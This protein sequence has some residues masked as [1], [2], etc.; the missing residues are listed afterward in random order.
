MAEYI[1]SKE[2]QNETSIKIETNDRDFFIGIEEALHQ[3]L[4][5]FNGRNEETEPFGNEDDFFDGFENISYFRFGN[6]ENFGIGFEKHDGNEL[7]SQIQ[8]TSEKNR[9][10]ELNNSKKSKYVKKGYENRK[11]KAKYPPLDTKWGKAYYNGRNYVIQGKN[12]KYHHKQLHVL[13]YQDYHKLTILPKV[14]IHHIDKNPI[15]N[16]IDNLIMLSASEHAKLH[17]QS[18]ELSAKIKQSKSRNTSGYFRVCKLKDKRHPNSDLWRYLYREDKK[19]KAITAKTIPEL[20]QKV[21]A[22]GLPWQKL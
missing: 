21:R 10:N 4:N 7:Q 19:Q 15:N 3:F 22:K 6:E 12:S 17:G 20:E 5:N 2:F 13:I 11:N 8:N 1:L 14:H 18:K 9:G 16:S